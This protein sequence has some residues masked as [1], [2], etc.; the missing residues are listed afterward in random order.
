MASC[1]T[2]ASSALGITTAPS[3]SAEMTS[4]GKMATPPQPTGSFQFTNVRPATDA[5]AAAPADYR[6]PTH[7]R[8]LVL[9][10]CGIG[11]A[12]ARDLADASFARQLWTLE[13][14]GNPKIAPATAGFLKA[15][16]G[17]RVATST[18]E[19]AEQIQRDLGELFE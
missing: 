9:S 13:L 12:G 16:F 19:E 2:S 8:E 7:L 18:P 5:G 11:D 3:P 10:L 17:G 15:R 1:V 6:G 4:P 14:R